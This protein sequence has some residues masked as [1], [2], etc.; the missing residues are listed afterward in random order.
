MSDTV[1]LGPFTAGMNN[2]ADESSLPEGSLRKAMNVDIDDAGN[3]RRRK[4]F[5]QVYSGTDIHSLHEGY[6]VEGTDLKYIDGAFNVTT[7]ATGLSGERISI[8]NLN[9]EYIFADSTVIYYVD[10]SDFGVEDP[11]GSL[12]LGITNGSLPTGKYLVSVL[13]RSPSTGEMSGATNS[14]EIELTSPGGVTV[15]NIPQ[16]VGAYEISV[17]MNTTDSEDLYYVGSYP[18][19]T[20]SVTI[21]SHKVNKH[22]LSTLNKN[23][24]VGGH[25]LRYFKGRL[26]AAQD[27]ILWFSE[28]HRYGL[29][30]Y[31]SN[32]FMFPTKITVV[33]AVTDGLY[34]VA[35]KT[36]FLAG[37]NPLENSLTVVSEDTAV[38]NTGLTIEAGNLGL[39][40]NVTGEAAFWYGSKGGV[41]GLP[42]GRIIEYSK[43]RLSVPVDAVNGTTM[44]SE[45]DGIHRLTT[46]ISTGGSRTKSTIGASDD[47]VA[48]H[49]RNGVVL[50]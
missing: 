26:Y 40:E 8:C 16:P 1:K 35:D 30:D 6:F 48:Q 23:R 12:L 10:G 14:V 5:T 43:D 4:G 2:I 27:E 24:M 7:Q 47:V 32:F 18:K 22:V 19:G 46:V 3:V 45:E 21:P 17:Y 49:I 38:P 39:Q 20:T 42:G 29:T 44:Y 34:I 13:F 37:S 41:L 36:Y 15:S 28:P 33:Q 11:Y 50:N 31:T 9:D 25:I